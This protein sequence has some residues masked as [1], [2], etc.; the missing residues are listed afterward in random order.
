MSL[1][2]DIEEEIKRVEREINMTEVDLRAFVQTCKELYVVG[3]TKVEEKVFDIFETY[4]NGL[5]ELRA[6]LN[7]LYRYK[8]RAEKK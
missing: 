1:T 5:A 6:E 8:G 2:L 4:I 7:M 3:D